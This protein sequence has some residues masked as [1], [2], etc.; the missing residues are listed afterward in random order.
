MFFKK[1]LV[2]VV[3]FFIEKEIDVFRVQLCGEDF[4]VL[5]VKRFFCF[6]RVLGLEGDRLGVS[7]VKRSEKKQREGFGKVFLGEV[8][9]IFLREL[10]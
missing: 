1:F 8:M 2:Y 5:V 9:W 10:I 6:F 4:G 7:I 3:L